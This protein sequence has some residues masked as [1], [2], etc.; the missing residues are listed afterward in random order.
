MPIGAKTGVSAA[1][2]VAT[3]ALGRSAGLAH[4]SAIGLLALLGRGFGALLLG[5]WAVEGAARPLSAAAIVARSGRQD[6]V[7]A[8]LAIAAAAAIA[9]AAAGPVYGDTDVGVAPTTFAAAAAALVIGHALARVLSLHLAKTGRAGWSLVSDLALVWP[10]AAIVFAVD[11]TWWGPFAIVALVLVAVTGFVASRGD[12]SAAELGRTGDWRL[13]AA[14]AIANSAPLL[15]GSAGA[16]LALLGLP[17]ELSGEILLYQRLGAPSM[18]L[19]AAAA[20]HVLG[21]PAHDLVRATATSGRLSAAV[22]APYAAAVVAVWPLLHGPLG[23]PPS[24]RIVPVVFLLGYLAHCAVGPVGPALQ[25]QRRPMADSVTSAI[26]GGLLVAGGLLADGTIEV[27]VA[28]VVALGARSLLAAHLLRHDRPRAG[29]E[30][31][32]ADAAVGHI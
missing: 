11:P 4:V 1:T 10:V 22:F 29:I 16:V 9:G 28:L 8:L 21:R 20:A 25:A 23:V 6:A 18:L 32:H 7:R 14:A 19:M 17:A 12:R 13:D 5:H 31:T 15:V 27:A 30:P 2:A 3:V 24:G 26:A